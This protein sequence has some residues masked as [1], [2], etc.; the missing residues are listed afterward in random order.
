MKV[1]PEA[2]KELWAKGL[3]VKEIAKTFNVARRTVY[4]WCEKLG[5]PIKRRKEHKYDWEKFKE[6]YLQG[7]SCVEI[8][9]RLGC[10]RGYAYE[11]KRRLNLPPRSRWGEVKTIDG[12]TYAVSEEYAMLNELRAK[13]AE[14]SGRLNEVD[15]EVRKIVGEL[16]RIGSELEGLK[17]AE[18][19]LS[20]EIA[21]KPKRFIKVLEVK[22][23]D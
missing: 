9:K 13:I 17:E 20:A 14:L 16:F 23:A 6:L 5:L 15:G 18:G 11:I 21:R 3:P 1:N 7:L 19:R 4:Y 12:V 2:L 8:A 22:K 10:S